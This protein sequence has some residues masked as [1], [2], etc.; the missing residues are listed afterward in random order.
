[1]KRHAHQDSLERHGR[2]QILK[3]PST[4]QDV[5][6]IAAARTIRPH[7]PENLTQ[8]KANTVLLVEDHDMVREL[9]EVLL[10]QLGYDVITAKDGEDALGCFQQRHKDICVVLSDVIMPRMDGWTMLAAIKRIRPNMPVV[11]ASGCHEKAN[12][13]PDKHA[14]APQAFLQKPFK[15]NEL[16]GTLDRVLQESRDLKGEWNEQWLGEWPFD[17]A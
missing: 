3:G 7:T 11:L 6:D 4:A 9:I 15:K 8:A 13:Q 16:K 1:M 5:T 17:R 2:I 14:I 12:Q 10:K